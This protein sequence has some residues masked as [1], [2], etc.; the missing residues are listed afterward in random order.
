[1]EVFNAFILTPLER[2]KV[3][4]IGQDPYH[5]PEQAHGLCFSVKK[6]IKVPPSLANIYKELAS[7]IDD[8]NIPQHGNLSSWAKQGVLMLN[9]VLTVERGV[10]HSHAKIGWDTFSNNVLQLLNDQ[11]QPIIFV[12]WGGHAIKKGR[13]ITSKQHIVLSA[14]HPSP[15]SAYRGFFG[16]GHF[17]AI[18]RKLVAMGEPAIDWQV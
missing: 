3:V 10:A 12:L 7:D 18:N 17:S 15:L 14:P 5:G 13:M 11:P 6:G 4:I 8:F 1:M 2:V 16:C 9:T